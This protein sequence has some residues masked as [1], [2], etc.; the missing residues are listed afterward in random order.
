MQQ[1]TFALLLP[2]F[3]RLLLAL[4]FYEG[5]T[6]FHSL[7]HTLLEVYGSMETLN[8]SKPASAVIGPAALL[9]QLGVMQLHQCVH[10]SQV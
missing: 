8:V 7:H 6:L 5:I 9:L 2:A 3:C 1:E 10:Q 4:L